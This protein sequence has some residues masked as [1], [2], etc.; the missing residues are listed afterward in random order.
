MLQLLALMI[1]ISIIRMKINE[2]KAAL[3]RFLKQ[4]DV[5]RVE[6]QKE[7]PSE[8]RMKRKKDRKKGMK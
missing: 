4:R 1:L 2:S 6:H 5:W 8:R 7:C 3:N